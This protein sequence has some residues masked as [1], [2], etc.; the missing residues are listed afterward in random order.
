MCVCTHSHTSHPWS[1]LNTS[2]EWR[3]FSEGGEGIVKRTGDR[4]E[5]RNENEEEPEWRTIWIFIDSVLASS[6]S[7]HGFISSQ[8]M[9][10]QFSEGWRPSNRPFTL[11]V[12]KEMDDD[13]GICRELYKG[14]TQWQWRRGTTTTTIATLVTVYLHKDAHKLNC[15]CPIVDRANNWKYT[16]LSLHPPAKRE[17]TTSR[18][19]FSYG[20]QSFQGWLVAPTDNT[21]PL[22]FLNKTYGYG[23]KELRQ[24]AGPL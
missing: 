8:R 17:T 4:K 23:S 11:W 10:H 1:Y 22:F 12:L 9:C 20:P 21:R 19:P 7:W 18:Q 6:C 2:Q 24:Q 5:G 13:D 14:P 15:G 3:R 16:H